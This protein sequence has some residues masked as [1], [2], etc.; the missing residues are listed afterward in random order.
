M[1]K[2]WGREL[3]E[4]EKLTMYRWLGDHNVGLIH[5][6]MNIIGLAQQRNSMYNSLIELQVALKKASQFVKLDEFAL[7]DF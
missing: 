1:E 2:T 6:V 5:D 4:H 7:L 3:V